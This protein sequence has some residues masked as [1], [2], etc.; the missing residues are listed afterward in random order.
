MESKLA[1]RA[2]QQLIEAMRRLTPEE[3]LNAHLQHC[4]LIIALS[5]AGRI[6]ASRQRQIHQ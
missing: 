5:R 4:Q 6:A 3:R 1:K 2:E